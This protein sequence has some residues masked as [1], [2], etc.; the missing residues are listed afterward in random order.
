MTERV[1]QFGGKYGLTALPDIWNPN[2]SMGL[3]RI[4]AEMHRQASMI[5]YINA[6]FLIGLVALLS[7]P[8]AMFMKAPSKHS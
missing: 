2:T 4:S 5:G 7:V 6:F 3:L 8:L 1:T